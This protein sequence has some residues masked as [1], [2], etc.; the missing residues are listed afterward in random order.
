MH[1][2]QC[3]RELPG[4]VCVWEGDG[5]ADRVPRVAAMSAPTRITFYERFE[6]DIVS[7]RKTITIRSERGRSFVPGTEVDVATHETGR[8]FCRIRILDVEPVLFEE[9]SDEHAL[10]ESMTLAELRSVITDI[11]PGVSR[12]FVLTFQ[13]V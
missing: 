4:T 2:V 5:L 9:L 3:S 12:L 13:V 10:Q 6:Q 11:Y 1:A 8:V 7:G